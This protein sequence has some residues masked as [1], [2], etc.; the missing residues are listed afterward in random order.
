MLLLRLFP[1]RQSLFLLLHVTCLFFA[2]RYVR[3]FA[4]QPNLRV[5]ALHAPL[6]VQSLHQTLDAG[7][8]HLLSSLCSP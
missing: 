2:L 1:S 3:P 7:Q 4:V 5:L 8:L 6:I